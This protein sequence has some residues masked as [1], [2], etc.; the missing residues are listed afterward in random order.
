MSN[1]PISMN[2]LY[3]SC[4]TLTENEATKKKVF[5]LAVLSASMAWFLDAHNISQDTDM[6]EI[7]GIVETVVSSM[8]LEAKE[9]LLQ[10]LGIYMGI[11][12]DAIDTGKAK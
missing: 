2:E 1:T 5:N 9:A 11:V 6:L 4:Q 12:I 3:Y 8:N 7:E 10:G